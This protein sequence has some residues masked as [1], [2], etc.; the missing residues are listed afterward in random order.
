MRRIGFN[1]QNKDG[2][3]EC[4]GRALHG[5]ARVVDGALGEVDDDKGT[6]IKIKLGVVG[7]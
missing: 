2:G 4:T 1:Y 6:V 3:G 5:I 7:C